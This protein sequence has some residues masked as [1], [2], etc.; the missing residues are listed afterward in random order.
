MVDR[1]TPRTTDADVR[2]VREATGVD[3]AAPVVTEPFSEWVLAGAFPA[4]RPAWEASGA[5]FVP[6]AA[7]FAQRKLWLLN[8]AHSLLAYLGIALGHETVAGAIAD[9]ACRGWVERW[10]SEAGPHLPQ[11]TAEVAD[12]TDALLERFANPRLRHPLAQIAQDGSVKLP[13][14]ILPVLRAFRESGDLPEAATCALGAWL[15]HLRAGGPA[16]SDV[17]VDELSAR[18]GGEP[19]HAAASVL[20][21]LDPDLG[22]DVE[23]VAAVGA[24]TSALEAGALP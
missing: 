19:R 20:Q 17:R 1:I 21:L 16:V 9:E 14:R 15:A 18:C 6:D 8:G 12:Y 4:G 23:L 7:P 11:S 3:D 24:V 22:G 2:S 13:V 10:W 5:R